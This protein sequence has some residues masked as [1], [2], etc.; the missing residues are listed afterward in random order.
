MARG[1]LAD[2]P[3]DSTAPRSGSVCGGQSQR[4]DLL[5]KRFAESGDIH[6]TV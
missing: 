2:K 4:V 5:E 1:C 6:A 3:D